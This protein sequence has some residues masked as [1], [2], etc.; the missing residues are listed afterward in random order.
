MLAKVTSFG[1]QG[2]Q[3]YPVMV[4]TDVSSGLPA[5]DT[6]GL[7]DAAV[8]EA[9][10][11]VRSAIRN[12]GCSFPLGRVTCNLAPADLK[13]EGSLYDLPIALSILIATEQIQ[14]P[15]LSHS[16][17]LGELALDGEIRPVP[18]VLSMALCAVRNGIDTLYL[19]KDNGKEAA[20]VRG[21]RV[22][23]LN[24]LEELLSVFRGELSIEPVVYNWEEEEIPRDEAHDFCYIR[25]QRMA[26][27]AMELA[28]AGG[29]NVLLSGPPGSGKTMLARAFPTILPRLTYEEA[30]E[31]TQI[32]SITG[33]LPKGSGL[34]QIRPFRSPHHNASIAALVGGGSNMRPGEISSAHYGVLF[35]DEFPEFSRDALEA[36][37]QPLEDGEVTISRARGSL[38][39]PARCTLIAAMNPCPCGYYG[40]STHAC[41]CT[42]PQILNYMRRISGPLL[43]RIDLQVELD[44]VPFENLHSSVQE[45]TSESIRARV[46]E[47]RAIQQARYRKDGITCNAHLQ[48][49]QIQKYCKLTPADTAMAKQ[50]YTSQS[51][52]TRAYTRVLKVAR[53]IADLAGSESIMTEH[54]AE[55]FQYRFQMMRGLQ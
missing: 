29:H 20:C 38:T 43:D 24:S 1:L 25:G 7:P 9:R 39:Y 54:L 51:M 31:V 16:A 32:H 55:A 15:D 19:P 27:R 8:K 47:A 37:R 53:T 49:R 28:A 22:I 2:I 41:T 46:E 48:S 45:E 40:S 6:V 44:S 42:T 5:F 4:E 14:A 18:G 21:L 26:K 10:E 36:L 12:S 3:G 23:A 35:L 50:Y 17:F 52:T 11:R 33:Q 30:L 34:M 13:K